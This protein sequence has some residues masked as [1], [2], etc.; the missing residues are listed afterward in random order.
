MG[1]QIADGGDEILDRRLP[2]ELPDELYRLGLVRRRSADGREGI[3]GKGQEA[4]PVR[5]ACATSAMCALRPR[6]SW[7]TRIPGEF[8]ISPWSRELATNLTG[9]TRIGDVLCFKARVIRRDYVRPGTAFLQ[10]A[11]RA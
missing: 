11:R 1:L 4:S 10:A 5:L 6:F 9:R 8:R 3:G 7:M 2:V